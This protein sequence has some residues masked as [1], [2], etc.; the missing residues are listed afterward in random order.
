LK[1]LA[2]DLINTK[3]KTF[4]EIKMRSIWEYNVMKAPLPWRGFKQMNL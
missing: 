4:D 3:I 2:V 1:S